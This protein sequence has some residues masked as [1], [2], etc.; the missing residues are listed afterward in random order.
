ME[1]VL[2]ALTSESS[3]DCCELREAL[4]VQVDAQGVDIGATSQEADFQTWDRSK[5]S[6]HGS[7]DLTHTVKLSSSAKDHSST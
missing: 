1:Q 2:V 3:L 6:I 4:T 7:M 5:F